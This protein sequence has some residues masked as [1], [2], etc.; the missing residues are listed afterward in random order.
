MNFTRFEAKLWNVI[1]SLN[2]SAAITNIDKNSLT[3]NGNFRVKNDLIALIWYSKEPNNVYGYTENRDYTNNVLN[4]TPN[5]SGYIA[6]F[7]DYN[8]KPTL[9]IRINGTDYYVTLGFYSPLSDI[10]TETFLPA[11]TIQLSHAWIDFINTSVAITFTAGITVYSTDA[12]GNTT[13][14]V[15]YTTYTLSSNQFDLDY[16]KGILNVDLSSYQ[17]ET[18][19]SSLTVT[20]RY[21]SGGIYILDFNN[22]YQGVHPSQQLKIP[23]NDIE[24]MF[25][26]LIPPDYDKN[27]ATYYSESKQLTANIQISASPDISLD[28]SNPNE[29]VSL[30]Y[31]ICEGYDD[32]CFRT[33]QRLFESEGQYGFKKNVDLYIG[34]THYYD[35]VWNGSSYDLITAYP[36]NQAFANWIQNFLYW[37]KQRGQDVVLSFSFEMYEAPSSWLQKGYDGSIGQS[38]WQPTTKFLS[39]TNQDVLAWQKNIISGL[40]QY[41]NNIGIT[42]RIQIGEPWWWWQEFMPGDVNN[43]NSMPYPCFYDDSTI[44]LYQSETGKSPPMIQNA[45]CE[46]NGDVQ[47]FAEWLNGKLKQRI[48]DL[49]NYIHSLG[50]M[51]Y[52]LYFPPSVEDLNRVPRLMYEVNNLRDIFNIFDIV[53]IEDYDWVTSDNFYHNNIYF[54]ALITSKIEYFAGYAANGTEQEWSRIEKAAK[55]SLSQGFKNVYIWSGTQ[56]RRDG[57]LLTD[58]VLSWESINMSLLKY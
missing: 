36:F 57:K 46:Y 45:W 15:D 18:D 5:F 9:T 2:T 26:T 43:K 19:K 21:H 3:I 58:D 7:D 42:P 23:T 6:N 47:S 44:N 56:I 49:V 8:V 27:D 11:A 20:Y 40:I 25:F 32:E 4:I 35:K 31:S 28:S 38:G 14:T 51:A 22:L 52:L 24:A 12:N 53:Q 34:A 48:T 50:G 41:C 39:P 10:I 55:V 13:S 33:P 29:N 16:A 37:A 1:T 17:Y 54:P 30:Q